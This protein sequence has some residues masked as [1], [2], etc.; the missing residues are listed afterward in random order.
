MALADSGRNGLE[1]RSVGDVA[2]LCLDVDLGGNL[3]EPLST[4]RDEDAAPATLGQEPRG[5]GTD[6]ARP[7]GDDGDANS[8]NSRLPAP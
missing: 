5:G 7:S 4:A 6:P 1:L 2:D 8:R 3:L